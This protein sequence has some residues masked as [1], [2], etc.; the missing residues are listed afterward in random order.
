MSTTK[1]DWFEYNEVK[2]RR[3]QS[4]IGLLLLVLDTVPLPSLYRGKGRKP[5][6]TRDIIICLILKIYYKISYRDLIGELRKY[7]NELGLE[8]I[9]HFNTLRRYMVDP[10]IAVLL[11]I[12]LVFLLQPIAALESIFASDATGFGTDRKSE[13]FR[14]VLKSQAK[15][16][17]SKNKKLRQKTKKKDFVKLH[18]TIGA[19][20]QMVVCAVSTIGK[21][22]EPTQFKTMVEMVSSIFKIKEWLGD[23]GYLSREACNLVSKQHGIPF[24]WPK[25]NSTARS[26]G[27]YAWAD[28]ITMFKKNL[29]F[30][31]KHCHQRSK[32]ESVFFVIKNYFGSTVFSR[33][34]ERQLNEMLFKVLAYNLCRLGE[35]AYYMKID[36]YSSFLYHKNDDFTP[37]ATCVL[38]QKSGG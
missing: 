18:I 36:I 12:L 32:V 2:T 9:P 20:S 38:P 17:N 4:F 29:E 15:K 37:V 10:R 14:V 23:A 19:I 30:F 6:P 16:K 33:R 8:K 22:R 26:K 13:Y 34:I 21:K 31:K 5:P 7:K 3:F 28:M 25:S 35:V 24:F 27:S 11:G 1:R